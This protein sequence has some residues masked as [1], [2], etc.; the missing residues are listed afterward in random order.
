VT[1]DPDSLYRAAFPR[2]SDPLAGLAD[3]ELQARAADCLARLQDLKARRALKKAALDRARRRL[4]D[5]S[6]AL[7]SLGREYRRACEE[8]RAIL[9]ED[10]KRRAFVVVHDGASQ[11]EQEEA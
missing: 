2:A 11:D 7:N 9:A 4:W 8:R 6:G 3:A 10:G 1:A 5:I